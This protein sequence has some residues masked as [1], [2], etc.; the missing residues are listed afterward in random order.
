M[1]LFC[2]II[3]QFGLVFC[4]AQDI[5]VLNRSNFRHDY[6]VTELQ[7]IEDLKDTVNSQFVANVKISGYRDSLLIN[8]WYNII[9]TKAKQLGANIYYIDSY[10]E[11]EGLLA[12]N[13]RMF[14]AGLNFMKTNR[15]KGNR[16]NI[17]IFNQGQTV[18]DTARFYL[19]QK[20]I[21]FDPKKYYVVAAKPYQV[22]NISTTSKRSR[23]LN[24]SF[25][26]DAASVFY[27][28][29]NDKKVFVKNV[30]NTNNGIN[31]SVGKNKPI[32]CD[33]NLGRFLV[34]MYK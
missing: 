22:Y 9:K 32:E 8:A 33:Y 30:T 12:I 23:K 27:I 15:A 25:P 21:E 31:I 34:E 24:H 11:H 17:Y 13:I 28:L 5:D 29:P 6:F 1:K 16:N 14:F 18:L 7:Y 10:S 2:C 26:K 3:F 20:K 4:F 19:N